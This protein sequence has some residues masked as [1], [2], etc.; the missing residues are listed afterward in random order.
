MMS[1]PSNYDRECLPDGLYSPFQFER[2]DVI[3][4]P[5]NSVEYSFLFL[6]CNSHCIT[7]SVTK[8]FLAVILTYHDQV[9]KLSDL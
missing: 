4:V 5:K 6:E 1:N 7:K 8:D 3:S 2:S 9:S